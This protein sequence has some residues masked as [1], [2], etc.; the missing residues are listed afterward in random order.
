[1]LTY[2]KETPHKTTGTAYWEVEAPEIVETDRNVFKYYAKGQRLQVCLP[3]YTARN[4]KEYPGK[5]VTICLDELTPEAVDLLRRA[6][7]L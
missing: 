3:A 1:M 6:L 5:T 7:E 2:V 4:G